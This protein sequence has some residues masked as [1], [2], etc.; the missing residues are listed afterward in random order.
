MNLQKVRSR[1]G[2]TLIEL[3]V[4]VSIIGFLSAIVISS[5]G[6]VRMKARDTRRLVDL[7]EI[8]K[9]LE[10][11]NN[12][13][14]IYPGEGEYYSDGSS[15]ALLAADLSP[16]ISR[17]PLDPLNKRGLGSS[18]ENGNYLYSYWHYSGTFS[19]DRYDLI[20]QVEGSN[21]PNR[22]EI[23]CWQWYT[24]ETGVPWCASAQCPGGFLY[25]SLNIIADH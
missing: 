19:T 3:L 2:F 13:Y 11:Y 24:S 1:F 21:N 7:R 5:L 9:A 20:G 14:G 6:G 23:K 18:W 8:R 15:W 25:G 17:L 10:L 22:C 12:D 16:Y 4:V